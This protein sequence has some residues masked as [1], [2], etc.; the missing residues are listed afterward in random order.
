M[1]LDRLILTITQRGK[2]PVALEEEILAGCKTNVVGTI[3]LFN[4]FTPLL[5]KGVQKKVIFI[6]SGHADLDLISKY[7]ID[8][9][10][11]YALGKAATNVVVAKFHAE[12]AKNGL[13]F[14][15]ISPGVVDTG[16][17]DPSSSK[18]ELTDLSL[19][20]RMMSKGAIR[21]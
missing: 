11:P 20:L 14:M 13:L 7:E 4:L 16:H 9:T 3:N 15:S 6:S 18:C 2:D 21:T 1:Q 8:V 12:H 17:F 19:S 5:Y 10:G